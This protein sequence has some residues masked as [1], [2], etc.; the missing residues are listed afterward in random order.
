MRDR[1]HR[2]RTLRA[3]DGFTL[4]EVT[5][6]AALMMIATVALLGALSTMTK[7]A[8]AAQRH[9]QALAVAQRDIERLRTWDYTTQIGL[10]AMPIAS[11]TDGNPASAP[12][13]TPTDPNYYVTVSGTTTSLKVMA[14]YSDETSVVRSTEPI[15]GPGD[16][17][18]TDAKVNPGPESFSYGRLS[19]KIYRYVTWR[20]EQCPAETASHI[21][22]PCAGGHESKRITVAVVPDRAADGTGPGKPIWISTVVTDPDATP[23]GIAPPRTTDPPTLAS[24][25]FYLTDTACS[26]SARATIAAHVTNDTSPTPP[27][28]G[29]LT[30]CASGSPVPDLMDQAPNPDA[31]S[32]PV[33]DYST[34]V[35]GRAVPAGLAGQAGLALKRNVSVTGCPTSYATASAATL[36]TTVHT[37]ASKPM[38][39]GG[40]T[41]PS[42]GRAALSV[43]THT[44]DGLAGDVTMC[45][46]LRVAGTRAVVGSGTFVD[47]TW[48]TA[49]AQVTFTWDLTGP[50]TV[51]SGDRLLLT[52]SLTPTSSN[53]VV[54]LYDHPSFQ[55]F[56]SVATST[57]LT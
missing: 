25:P 44:V 12:S 21:Q 9:Q 6:A 37:W 30:G 3:D 46:T 22:N 39:S 24:Q 17:T 48:P 38:P 55:S 15:V 20:A 28:T 51:A 1:V 57:P 19:G 35:A 11:A 47:H 13:N 29:A 53:N 8:Q 50:V 18:L 7:G 2:M 16:A 23:T 54:L 56:V 49:P 36:K 45:A 26:R 4:I 43:W 52:L 32:V 14:R 5:M 31:E 41:I 33:Y 27:S 42:G 40:F 10:T 34:D